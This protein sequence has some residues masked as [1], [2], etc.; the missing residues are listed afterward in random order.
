MTNDTKAS[1]PIAPSLQERRQVIEPPVAV[2]GVTG[3]DHGG[4]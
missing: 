3:A 4:S 2:E 1:N